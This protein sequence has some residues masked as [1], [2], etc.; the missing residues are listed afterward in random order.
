M[1]QLRRCSLSHYIYTYYLQGFYTFQVVGLGIS[2]PSTS[3]LKVCYS[4]I[5]F[6]KLSSFKD[7]MLPSTQND[8]FD[9]MTA[10]VEHKHLR[11]NKTLQESN[12]TRW[13]F[14][15]STKKQQIPPNTFCLS[16]KKGGVYGDAKPPCRPMTWKHCKP[17]PLALYEVP[18]TIMVQAHMGG[19]NLIS[20]LKLD[21]LLFIDV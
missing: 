18:E 6:P 20:S 11:C 21:K 5:F 9:Q 2:E 10:P 16:N 17:R 4:P 14:A 12:K 1:H 13:K 3:M 7:W 8:V 15:A 19:Y